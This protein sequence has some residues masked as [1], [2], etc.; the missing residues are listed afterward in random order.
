MRRWLVTLALAVVA[1]PEPAQAHGFRLERSARTVTTSSTLAS[2]LH[3]PRV[4]RLPASV[5]LE[6]GAI[7]VTTPGGT[8]RHT[9]GGRAGLSWVATVGAHVVVGFAQHTGGHADT[10]VA[11]D[12]HTGALAWRRTVDSLA[13]A[14]LVD[15]LLA[16]ERAGTLDVIDARTGHT[17]GTTPLVGQHLQTVARSRG[18]DLHL[19]TRGDLV[20]VD[21]RGS[22]RWAVPS[23]S[24]GNP[25]VTPATVIDAWVDRRTHRYG[26]VSYDATTGRQLDSIDL[27]PTG[28]W[29][30]LE[31]VVIAPDGANDVLVSAMF[32]VE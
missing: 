15:D 4:A 29:Y 32:A 6:A 22:V 20:A 11:V 23:S 12:H 31:Q 1:L 16:I 19:K 9:L 25:T 14:E 21:R 26:I 8:T 27:G 18:G 7:R 10:V 5:E 2:P 30:D 24:I 17:V 13:A 3:E 28:G